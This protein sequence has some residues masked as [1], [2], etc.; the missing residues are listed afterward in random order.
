M[1]RVLVCGGRDFDDE[2]RLFYN[3]NLIH[4]SLQ[5]ITTLIHGGANGADKM[6]ARWAKYRGDIEII[7]CKADWIKHG[8]AAGPIRNKEMLTHL[9]DLV[10]AFPGGS[11]T[12]NMIAQATKAEIK[13]I[14]IQDD[15]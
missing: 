14:K 4:D 6:A 3:M 15:V 10:V 13:V 12:Q 9:P 8:K 5:N 2:A 11:G 1:M 7:E